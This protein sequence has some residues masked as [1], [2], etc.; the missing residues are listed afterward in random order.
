MTAAPTQTA[1][2]MIP[3]S[4]AVT[5]KVPSAPTWSIKIPTPPK[6]ESAAATPNDQTQKP[7]QLCAPDDRSEA[8]AVADGLLSGAADSPVRSSASCL[9]TLARN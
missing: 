2:E 7:T 3:T 1:A 6:T 9:S 4:S 8:L 5:A